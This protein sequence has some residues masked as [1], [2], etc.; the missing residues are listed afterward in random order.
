MTGPEDFLPMVAGLVGLALIVL[1]WQMK[2]PNTIR[3]LNAAAFLF[4]AAQL[5][6]LSAWTGS[7]MM[8][9]AAG[10]TTLSALVKPG[11]WLISGFFSIN[12]LLGFASFQRPIDILPIIGNQTGLFSFF[13]KSELVL[14][15]LAPVGTI[16]WGVHN[17][18]VGAYSQALADAI[19]LCSMAVG[20]LRSFSNKR[21][22]G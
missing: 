9:V 1:S 6:L 18:V 22:N 4:F 7:L 12:L 20:A 21:L 3:Y 10:Y 14:R 16:M 15:S 11:F 13:A 19:I 17:V 5:A 8:L 2:T